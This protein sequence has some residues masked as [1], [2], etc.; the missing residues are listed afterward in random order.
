[1]IECMF[2]NVEIG[3]DRDVNAVTIRE[4]GKESIKNSLTAQEKI[5]NRIN[6]KNKIKWTRGDMRFSLFSGNRKRK[7]HF[8]IVRFRWGACH[9]IRKVR[10]LSS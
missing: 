5:R 8:K 6:I 9:G 2:R 7:P 1:M 4:E 3:M 10:L